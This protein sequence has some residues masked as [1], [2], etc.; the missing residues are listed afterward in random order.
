MSGRKLKNCLKLGFGFFHLAPAKMNSTYVKT[1]AKPL[2]YLLHGYWSTHCKLWIAAW[3]SWY[4]KIVLYKTFASFHDSQSKFMAR[5]CYWCTS[6][7]MYLVFLRVYVVILSI[8]PFQ[9]TGK[10][11]KNL[12][13]STQRHVLKKI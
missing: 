10:T 7:L 9:K 8:Y 12:P 13:P 6:L 5:S 1:F 3:C 2:F 11:S 4:L